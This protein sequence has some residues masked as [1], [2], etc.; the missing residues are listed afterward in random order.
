MKYLLLAFL[1]SIFST[2]AMADYMV[3]G[4][5]TDFTMQ[6]GE[7][8]PRDIYVSIG[9]SQG[10]K[11]G[12]FLDVFRTINTTDELNQKTGSNM[13]FR[14]GKLKV[15]HAEPNVAVARVV[16]LANTDN[17]PISHFTNI[18]VGDRVE[19]SKK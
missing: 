17:S 12:S 3:Y 8:T 14:I 13:S 4:V 1:L 6:D 9:T 5:K 19:A 16:E 2:T 10:I 15:I 11:S 18:A 7:K